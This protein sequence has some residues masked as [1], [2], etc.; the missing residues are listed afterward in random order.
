MA[1]YTQLPEVF[2]FLVVAIN[3]LRNYL[4]YNEAALSAVSSAFV[5]KSHC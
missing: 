1:L 5:I 3:G 4:S 2:L